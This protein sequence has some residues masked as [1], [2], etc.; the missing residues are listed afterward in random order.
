MQAVVDLDPEAV[1]MPF[2]THNW[3]R[4]RLCGL[5]PKK[6][7]IFDLQYRHYAS[8]PPYST[9]LYAPRFSPGPV[10]Y[11]MLQL[12][13]SILHTEPVQLGLVFGMYDQ[14]G[15]STGCAGL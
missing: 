6:D 15:K 1:M 12:L 2:I 9:H 10:V 14:F 5:P 4:G 11:F 3:I 7:A 8:P 13:L